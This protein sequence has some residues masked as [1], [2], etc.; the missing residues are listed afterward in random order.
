MEDQ[1]MGTDT[2]SELSSAAALAAALSRVAKL[3]SAATTGRFGFIK[4]RKTRKDSTAVLP[5]TRPRRKQI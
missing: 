2:V 3:F 1:D 4:V 5:W